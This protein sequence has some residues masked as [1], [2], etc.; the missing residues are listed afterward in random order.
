[1]M[2]IKKELERANERDEE[3][4]AESERERERERIIIV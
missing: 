2:D 3:I 4:V 1:V